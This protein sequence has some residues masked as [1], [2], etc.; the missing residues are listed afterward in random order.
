MTAYIGL[1]E[2]G[3]ASSKDKTIV[4]SGAAGATGSNVCQ[5]AKNILG[6]KKVIG[7]CGTDEKCAFLKNTLHVDV[8]LNYRSPNFAQEFVDATPDFIDL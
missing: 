8:A 3:E 7:I 5:I 2:V 4:V 1:I 6:V